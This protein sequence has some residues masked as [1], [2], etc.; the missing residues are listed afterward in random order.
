[1]SL[2]GYVD[3]V[4]VG[5]ATY[6][7]TLRQARLYKPYSVRLDKFRFDRYVGTD[8]PKNYSSDV[9]VFDADGNQVREQHIAMNEP[10]RYAGETFYQANFDKTETTT[11]LQVVKNPGLINFGL[12]YASVDYIACAFVGIGLL[13]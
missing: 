12:F 8:K 7:M 9:R 4:P 6:R 1:F 11:I 3:A 10:M 2:Q 5:D 13:L